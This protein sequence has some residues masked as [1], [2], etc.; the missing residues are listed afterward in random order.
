MRNNTRICK[1]KEL[2]SGCHNDFYN[3]HNSQGVKE[4]WNYKTAKVVTRYRIGWWIPMDKASNFTE[5]K[6]LNCY[7]EDGAGKR[8]YCEQI[9]QHL[10][11]EWNTLKKA[12]KEQAI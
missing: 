1:S 6:V 2:C 4:C 5:V 7:A 8:A 11:A 10:K 12:T 3:G 9:P